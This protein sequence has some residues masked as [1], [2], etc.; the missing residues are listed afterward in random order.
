MAERTYS[1]DELAAECGI[2]ARTLRSWVTSKALPKP[3]GQG[4]A[5]RYSAG[6][7]LRARV[8]AQLRQRG[9]SLQAIRGRIAS[10]S[11]AQLNVLLTAPREVDSAQQPPPAPTYP[12]AQ[13][14]MVQLM[15]GMALMVHSDGGPALRR[16]ADEIYRHYN[17]STRV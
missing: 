12:F 14:Q 2:N 8:I 10:L 1:I 17:I 5:A 15:P 13:W 16:I 9:E 4:R 7:L 6:H 3:V 11:P